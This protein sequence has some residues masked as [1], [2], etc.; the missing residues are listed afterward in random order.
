MIQGMACGQKNL[1]EVNGEHAVYTH[2]FERHSVSHTLA[3][4]MGWLGGGLCKE[5][6]MRVQMLTVACAKVSG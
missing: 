6:M 2:G 5:M 1:F 3:S 4:V